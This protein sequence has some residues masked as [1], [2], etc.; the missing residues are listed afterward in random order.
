LLKSHALLK[1]SLTR[2]TVSG[3]ISQ[4]QRYQ[5][6][7]GR[8]VDPNALSGPLAREHEETASDILCDLSLIC[9]ILLGE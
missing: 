3:P 6:S 9:H 8:F 2:L 7:Q 1:S 4:T 5:F